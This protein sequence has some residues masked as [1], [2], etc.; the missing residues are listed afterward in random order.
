MQIVC[1]RRGGI[2]VLYDR[3]LV[4]VT[5]VGYFYFIIFICPDW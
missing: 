1:E 4:K 3:G 2:Y 5:S